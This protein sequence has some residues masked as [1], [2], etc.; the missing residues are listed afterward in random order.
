MRRRLSGR[1]VDASS[2]AQARQSG[3]EV[4]EVSS[5]EPGS[6]PAGDN[7]TQRSVN[8]VGRPSRPERL[9]GVGKQVAIQVEGCVRLGHRGLLLGDMRDSR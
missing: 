7:L 3:L 2:G 1:L 6:L 9:G 4:R 8:G 5:G